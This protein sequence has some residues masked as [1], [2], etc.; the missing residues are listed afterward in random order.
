MGILD[1]G[2]EIMRFIKFCLFFKYCNKLKKNRYYE[3]YVYVRY[4]Y[5]YV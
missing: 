2:N 4:I 1:Y 3:V 5:Y